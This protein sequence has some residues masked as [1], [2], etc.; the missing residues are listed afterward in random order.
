MATGPIGWRRG[1]FGR[2]QV[3]AIAALSAGAGGAL[4]AFHALTP[5]ALQFGAGLINLLPAWCVLIAAAGYVAITAA[6]EVLFRGVIMSYLTAVVG[7]WPALVV[8]AAGFGV[9]HLHGYPHGRSGS[10]SPPATVC[11]SG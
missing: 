8:Q 3:W 4:V 6:V 1:R 9:L 2:E 5:P 10:R 7:S 11:C